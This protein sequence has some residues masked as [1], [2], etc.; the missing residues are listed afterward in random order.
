MRRIL[1]IV[2]L[3]L[4]IVFAGVAGL[5]FWG[6]P[7]QVPPEPQLPGTVV[8]GALEHGGRSRAWMA[9]LPAKRA[10][11]PALVIVLH[12]SMGTGAEARRVFGYD[13]DLLAEQHGFI[14]VYPQGFEGHWNDC[15]V[16]GSYSAKTEKIDDVGFLHALVDRFAEHD[17][18]DRAHV[19]VTGVSNGGAMTICLA[20]QTPELARAFAA[21]VSS[22]PTREN[23]SIAPSGRPVSML[24]MNG[25]GDP[26]NPWNGGDVV[27]YGVYG[28]RG[29]VLSTQASIDYFRRLD[30][31]DSAPART[32]F[33]DRDTTDGSTAERE[34]W[35]ASGKRTV[36]LITIHGGGHS[37]PHPA[38]S[39]R[40]LLGHSNRDF[41]A[42]NEIWEFFSQAP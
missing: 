41:H 34:R 35:T 29:P 39:E 1:R 7:R 27:L 5:A 16:R 36:T 6:L 9:Y 31:L 22:V 8:R 42:A 14:V 11:H 33:P 40:R 37:V 20:L 26:F 28:N 13:F 23:M 24:L 3:T 30:G 15:K 19:Y 12:P 25:T 38:T 32:A 21:V 10:V 2:A 17:V 18:A 4:L